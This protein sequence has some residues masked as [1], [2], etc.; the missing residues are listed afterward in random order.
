MSKSQTNNL[1]T[2]EDKQETTCNHIIRVAFETA[3]D[4]EFDYLVPDHI[5]PIQTGQRVEA[6][7]GRNDKL[8]KGFCVEADIPPERAFGSK[9]RG[10]H[11]K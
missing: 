5:W 10:I 3:A 6:P 2:N 4:T 8:E 11:L 9:D 7:F 1:F